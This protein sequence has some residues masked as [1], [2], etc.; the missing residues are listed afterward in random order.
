MAKPKLAE[1]R[2]TFSTNNAVYEKFLDKV[3]LEGF[4]IHEV[5]TYLMKQYSEEK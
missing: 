5:L 2:V 4:T 1:K 3:L